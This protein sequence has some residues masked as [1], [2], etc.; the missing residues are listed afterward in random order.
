MNL[1][2]VFFNNS[3]LM[4]YLAELCFFHFFII[5]ATALVSCNIAT[6]VWDVLA[7]SLS[8]SFARLVEPLLVCPGVFAGIGQSV[9]SCCLCHSLKTTAEMNDYNEN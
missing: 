5:C 3:N 4:I 9:H 2:F 6:G 1:C 8:S 7:P